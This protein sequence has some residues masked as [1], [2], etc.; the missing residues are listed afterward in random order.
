MAAIID[1][2][3]LDGGGRA[4]LS[5]TQLA[6]R[7]Q[8]ME[9]DIWLF[10][11]WV[12]QPS[13]A[14]TGGDYIERFH[15]PLFYL[16]SGDP[17]RLAASLEKYKS[18]F[19]LQVR[20]AL[21]SRHINWQTAAGIRQLR[22]L[23]QRINSRISRSSGKT[24]CGLDTLLKIGT[25]NPNTDIGIASKSDPAAFDMCSTIGNIMR[26]DEYAMYFPER[27][28]AHATGKSFN[29]DSYITQ[30]WIRFRGRTNPKQETI[31]A[32]GINSQWYGRHYRII[33]CDDLA[34]TEAKQGVATVE[35]ALRFIASMSG[36]SVADQWGGTREIFNGTITGPRD[37]NSVLARNSDYISVRVPIWTKPVAATVRN[38]MMDGDPTLPEWYSRDDIIRKRKKEL[39]NPR[40][41]AIS[42]LQNFEL[43]AHE[44]GAMQFTQEMLNRAKFKWV[45]RKRLIR[46]KDGNPVEVQF[47]VIRRYLWEMDRDGNRVPKPS[48]E[49][50][51]LPPGVACG[52]YL[53]CTL[54]NH[55]YVEHDPKVM[56]R[57]LG[58]DQSFAASG[59]RWSVSNISR[60]TDNVLYALKG[61]SGHGYPVMIA[62]IPILCDTEYGGKANYPRKVGIESNMVQSNTSYWMQE[63]DAVFGLLSHRI[64]KVSPGGI[65]KTARIFNNVFAKAEAGTLLFD[66]EDKEFE[67]EA[68][69]YDPTIDDPADDIMDSIAIGVVLHDIHASDPD[70]DKKAIEAA[71]RDYARDVDPQTGVDI[72]TN[73]ADYLDS[74][75]DESWATN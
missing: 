40:F 36:L 17:I 44:D 26:T 74:P 20:S 63:N 57:V 2:E 39:E 21:V 10:A 12:C 16:L 58:V 69:G 6:E 54:R 38:M 59:D 11:K 50:Q 47:R 28:F 30:E 22:Q 3:V 23:L 65:A 29:Y 24:T 41:G 25:Y 66:P 32:R 61:K 4:V 37:D 14:A 27:L 18:E 48:S 33:Y 8:K 31:E 9:A 49:M 45:T 70:A 1:S 51:P 19:V 73:F 53:S 7:K 35:D 52:C 42:W 5:K 55:A 15:R 67:A 75:F 64:V 46:G 43:T 34:S 13:R 72:S 71:D 68:L 56:P 62:A 60:D